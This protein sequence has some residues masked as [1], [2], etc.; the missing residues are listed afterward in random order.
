M[1]WGRG[2]GGVAAGCETRKYGD[3][4][5]FPE[6]NQEKPEKSCGNAGFAIDKRCW[7][8]QG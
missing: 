7:K 3:F 2:F 4:R 5:R 8:P 1:R 6:K